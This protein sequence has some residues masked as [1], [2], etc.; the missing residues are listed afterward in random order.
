MG[1]PH[2]VAK[3]LLYSTNPK[4]IIF[5]VNSENCECIILRTLTTKEPDLYVIYISYISWS[6][7]D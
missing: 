2:P 4:Y 7:R 3:H 6:A 5:L 1:H